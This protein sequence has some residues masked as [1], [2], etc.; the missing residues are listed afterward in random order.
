MIKNA[1]ISKKFIQKSFS[2]KIIKNFLLITQFFDVLFGVFRHEIAGNGHSKWV[3][4]QDLS[5]FTSYA[6][7][8]NDKNK[9]LPVTEQK[10]SKMATV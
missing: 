9:P 10:L 2:K 5:N 3:L 7:D 6:T 1:W 4:E 8:Y